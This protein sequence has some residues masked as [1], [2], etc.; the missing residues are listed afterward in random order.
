MKLT[1]E[2]SCWLKLPKLKSNK[3]KLIY[4]YIYLNKT[5]IHTVYVYKQKQIK[6]KKASNKITQT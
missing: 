3:C 6:M 1:L 4:I 2:M 5:Y